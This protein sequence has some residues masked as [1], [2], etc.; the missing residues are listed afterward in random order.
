MFRAISLEVFSLTLKLPARAPKDHLAMSKPHPRKDKRLPPTP[1]RSPGKR[2]VH[3]LHGRDLLSLSAL[4]R[5]QVLKLFATAKSVKA[6]ISKDRKA[7][8]GKAVILLFEKPSL[9][10]RISFEVGI[11]KLGGTAIYMDHSNARLGERESVHDYGKNL[12]RWVQ[13]IV[14]RVFSQTVLDEMAAAASVP[15][16]NALSDLFHPCQAL[17]DF[18]T[19]TEHF[20]GLQGVKLAY[21]G[22]GNN[23]CNSLMHAA[24]LLGVP[25]TVI[26]PEGFEPRPE[27]VAEARSLAKSS[28][29]RIE[30]SND[31][32]A[33]SG[34]SAVYTDVWVSM[35]QG[36]GQA[37]EAAKRR[38]AF[39]PYQ[40]NTNLMAIAGPDAKF[41]HCLPAHRGLEVTDPVIDS[42]NSVVYDQAENRMHVQNAL[43]LHLLTKRL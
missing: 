12:E 30:L 18:F 34:H 9:R 16:I 42:T 37:D 6:D 39:Q 24:G 17:A 40:V 23:V 5:A 32:S 21:V 41:M 36:A 8:D 25:M 28:G 38:K 29:S 13:C 1:P 10:T 2:G 11:A 20:K 33:V 4:D 15:V 22:D 27:I 31:P 7:L 43:L 19:L 14:A 3:P 35:G 26:T